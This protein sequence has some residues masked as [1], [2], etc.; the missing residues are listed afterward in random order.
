MKVIERVSVIRH[1]SKNIKEWKHKKLFQILRKDD[2]WITAYEN[3]KI[4][5][6]S[7]ITEIT[8]ETL[9]K[10]SL[11]KLLKLREKVVNEN[12]QF[13][14]LNKIKIPKLDIE[15]K[16]LEL[17]TMND[18][19][20]QEVIRIILQAIYEPCFLKQNFSCY[21]GFALHNILKYIDLKFRW[22]DAVIENDIK[23]IID[24]KQLSKILSK[25]IQDVRFL[26]LIKQLLN[27]GVLQ[28]KKFTRSNFGFFQTNII[29]PILTNIYYNEFDKWV[30]KKRKMIE[31]P[32]KNQRNQQ[33]NQLSYQIVKITKQIKKLD[34]KLD[35]YKI[36]L[37]KLKI[38]KKKRAKTFNF[39]TNYIQIEYIRYLD[40]WI[41]G[42][43]GTK[44][45]ARQ[46]QLEVTHFLKVKL[47]QTIT[48]INMKLTDLRAGKANFLGYEIY[49]P[50]NRKISSYMDLSSSIIGPIRLRLRFDIP[51]RVILKRMEK[52]GYIKKLVNGYRS[53]SKANYTTVKDIRI[54]KQFTQVWKRLANY[55]S[56]ST[57]F[58][59]LQDIHYLLHLSCAM[60][61]S[62]RHR[63]TVRKIF[64]KHG[65]T[66][67]VYYGKIKTN[68][69]YRKEWSINKKIW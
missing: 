25:K 32:L 12:Y 51:I 56:G 57:N 28:Q 58:T 69:P 33:Y 62:H 39:A 27:C 29:S 48:F 36:V 52:R 66:L 17:P 68:F 5:K 31:Y 2:I 30:E 64:A 37:K 16:F 67:T 61:L 4:N 15:R 38:I 23:A 46:L 21:Q 3:I 11:N 35:D 43:S 9:N 63:L 20:V 65:K 6:V 34:K 22:I 40:N 53:I 26:N 24:N 54:V 14:K 50:R 60:T 47:K 49:L 44:V 8:M 42:I 19:I 13:K 18:K 55:Y 41:I 1:K 7:V 10:I 45:L 59:K